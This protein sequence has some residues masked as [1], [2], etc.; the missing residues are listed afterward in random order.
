MS[1]E[2][3]LDVNPRTTYGQLMPVPKMAYSRRDAAATLTIKV[4][5][6]DYLIKSGEMKVRRIGRRVV[7]THQELQNFLRRDH[8]KR[9]Q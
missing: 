8:L 6:L 3:Y 7:I 9:V 2:V 5:K 4:R 1:L